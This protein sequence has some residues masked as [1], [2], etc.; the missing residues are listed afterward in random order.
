MV[1][2][3]KDKNGK[4]R[5]RRSFKQDLRQDSLEPWEKRRKGTGLLPKTNL[6]TNV[7]IKKKKLLSMKIL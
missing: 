4:F 5:S 2:A 3:L 7:G 6:S 1:W